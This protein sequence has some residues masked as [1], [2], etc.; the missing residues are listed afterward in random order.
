LFGS[1]VELMQIS[2]CDIMLHLSRFN[3]EFPGLALGAYLTL[4]FFL[5]FLLKKGAAYL[6]FHSERIFAGVRG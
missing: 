2:A 6:F 1:F 4:V 3:K 5:F